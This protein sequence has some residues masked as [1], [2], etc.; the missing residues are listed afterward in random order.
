MTLSPIS[1]PKVSSS[2]LRSSRRE[3]A[4]L[5]PVSRFSGAIRPLIGFEN[6]IHNQRQEL[7]LAAEVTLKT[8]N[9]F[10]NDYPNPKSAPP[11]ELAML[12]RYLNAGMSLPYATRVDFGNLLVHAIPQPDVVFPPTRGGC[13]KIEHGELLIEDTLG[14]WIRFKLVI[15]CLRTNL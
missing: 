7:L 2:H 8:V 1:R 13:Y 15:D 11:A 6:L 5:F 10:L 4:Y 14:G 12:S 9:Y 3:K